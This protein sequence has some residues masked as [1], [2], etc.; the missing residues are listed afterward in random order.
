MSEVY[1][2]RGKSY[3]SL[4]KA[5]NFATEV[6]NQLNEFV[7][8][9]NVRYVSDGNGLVCKQY[10]AKDLQRLVFGTLRNNFSAK[11]FSSPDSE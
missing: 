6:S 7:D 2:G 11:F 9:S 8:I 1:V 5:L 10:G 3:N 4:F